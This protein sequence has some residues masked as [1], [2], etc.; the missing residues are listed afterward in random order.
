[1]DWLVRYGKIDASHPLDRPVLA[2]AVRLADPTDNWA[3][4]RAAQGGAAI[5]QAWEDRHRALIH[6]RTRLHEAEG[7]DPDAVLNSLLHAHHIRA[8]G[9]DKD[10]ERTCVRLARAAALAWKARRG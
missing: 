1:M 5:L 4:L 3:A 7:I 9:I 8:T 10:D 2:E 6:Y